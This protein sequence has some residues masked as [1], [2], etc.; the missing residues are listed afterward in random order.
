M[1]YEYY[2]AELADDYLKRGIADE[3]NFPDMEL[4]IDQMVSCLNGELSL[5]RQGGEGPV[6]K[7]MVSNYTKHRMIPGP[8]G[9][10]YGKDH[11]IFMCI[12]FY[13][14]NSLSMDQI[15]KLMKPLLDNYSSEWD[16]TVDLSKMYRVFSEYFRKEE[17]ELPG[18]I[19]RRVSDAK[20]L[21]AKFEAEDDTSELFTLITTLIME[22]YAERFIAEKLLEE[23]FGGSSDKGRK[24]RGR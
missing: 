13:L 11:L 5:Y 14:K 18:Q 1:R 9:K 10:K 24:D 20:K 2:A 19:A 22:S 16:D 15:Q 7:A 21:C 12:V 23:Y 8:D 4:Y 3:K 6:T 17:A